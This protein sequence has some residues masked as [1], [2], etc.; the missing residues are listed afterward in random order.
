MP[1]K[2][3]LM[4]RILERVKNVVILRFAQDDVVIMFLQTIKFVVFV[5]IAF[6]WH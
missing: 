4:R 2:L 6:N 3:A 5:K 1:I